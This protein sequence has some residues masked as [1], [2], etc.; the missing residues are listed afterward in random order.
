MKKCPF[1]KI[2]KNVFGSVQ[3]EKSS[4]VGVGKPKHQAAFA[5]L[6]S[7]EIFMDC[8]EKEC[9]AWDVDEKKCSYFQT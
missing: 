9:M 7:E 4:L 1:R 8:I 5:S 3:T 6:G 2:T